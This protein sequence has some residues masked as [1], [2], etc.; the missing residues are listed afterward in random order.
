MTISVMRRLEVRRVGAVLAVGVLGFL[1]VGDAVADDQPVAGKKLLLK[2]NESGKQHVLSVQ[3]DENI[4]NGGA[5]NIATM[6]GTLEIYYNDNPSNKATLQIPAPWESNNGKVIKYKNKIAPAGPSPVK[7]AVVKNGELAKVISKSLG[8][9]TIA[10]PGP[11]GMTTVLIINNNGTHR[12]CTKYNQDDIKVKP[13]QLKAKNGVPVACPAPPSCSDGIQNQNETGVDCGGICQSNFAQCCTVNTGCGSSTDCCS[14]TCASGQCKCAN[15]LYTFTV[16]SNNG[17]SVDPAEWPGGTAQ[18][19]AVSGCDVT[20]NRPS[21]N[22]DLV[23]NLGDAFA[24]N[25]FSG[26]SSCF[27]TSGEDGDG[28]Q[29]NSCPPVGI[30]SCQSA[31]PSCSA[32]LNGSGQSQYSVQCLQ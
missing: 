31:R 10:A 28:C 22:I 1:L 20:I 6:S 8:G 21:G 18:Q 24:V 26:Y 9:L 7:V 14:G 12:L 2:L 5:A 19:S 27:G 29:V 11:G 13:G 4:H 16:N 32:A 17:G 25:T 15:N 3:R 23:G 30:G